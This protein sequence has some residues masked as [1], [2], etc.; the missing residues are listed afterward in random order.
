LKVVWL[1]ALV[2]SG[3]FSIMVNLGMIVVGFGATAGLKIGL[4][5]GREGGRKL[6]PVNEAPPVLI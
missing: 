4:R 1:S 3:R 5:G 2:V 6:H